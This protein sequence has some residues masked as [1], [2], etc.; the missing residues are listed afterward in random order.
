MEEAGAVKGGMVVVETAF[1]QPLSRVRVCDP[2]SRNSVDATSYLAQTHRQCIAHTGVPSC[3][4]CS[5]FLC[6]VSVDIDSRRTCIP[7]S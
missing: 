7:D 2:P 5:S 6:W 3:H 1:G 4:S